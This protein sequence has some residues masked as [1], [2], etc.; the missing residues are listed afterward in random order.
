MLHCSIQLL[1]NFNQQVMIDVQQKQ[2]TI[3]VPKLEKRMIDVPEF[4]LTVYKYQLYSLVLV[5]SIVE[6]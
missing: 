2:K 4:L 6:K 1:E 3:L 5:I